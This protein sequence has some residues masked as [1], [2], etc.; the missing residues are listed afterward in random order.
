MST[1]L[2]LA[3]FVIFQALSCARDDGQTATVSASGA[4]TPMLILLGLID[5]LQSSL[6]ATI[7]IKSSHLTNPYASNQPRISNPTPNT[8]HQSSRTITTLLLT[9]PQSKSY[10]THH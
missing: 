6:L 8:K 1:W 4:L 7:H 2:L 10:L 5:S 3:P 9:N